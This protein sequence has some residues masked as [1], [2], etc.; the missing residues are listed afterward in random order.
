MSTGEVTPLAG[1]V[2]QIAFLIGGAVAGSLAQSTSLARRQFDRLGES[3]KELRARLAEHAKLSAL[4]ARIQRLSTAYRDARARTEG[5]SAAFEASAVAAGKPTAETRRLAREWDKARLKEE[6]LLVGLREHSA[7]AVELRGRIMGVSGAVRDQRQEERRLVASLERVNAVMARNAKLQERR[8]GILRARS[9][10]RMGMVDAYL[11]GRVALGPL[12]AATEAESAR[13]RLSTV[14][15]GPEKYR[16]EAVRKAWEVGKAMAKS[17]LTGL[18]EG[19]DIQYALESAGLEA[20]LSRAAAPVVA[21]VAKLTRGAPEEVGE[22]LATVYNNLSKNFAGSAEQRFARVGDLLT[23]VQFKYQIRDFG[24]L[25]ESMKY[26][27]AGINQYKVDAEQSFGVIGALNTYGLQGSMAGTAFSAMVRGLVKGTKD[28]RPQIVRAKDG[29]MD[30]VRTLELLKQDMRFMTQDQKARFLTDLEGDEGTRGIVP[31]LENLD[32]LKKDLADVREGSKG[33]VSKEMERWS[34]TAE[35]RFA[36][37]RGAVSVGAEA[38]GVALLPFAETG[39][40]A[41]TVLADKIVA[42]SE[43]YPLATK[44][45]ADFAVG[46]IGAKAAWSVGKY[47]FSFPADFIV[48]IMKGKKALDAF[49]LTASG[50]K[51][52]GGLKLLGSTIWTRVIP[53]VWGFTVALLTNPLTW[54][55]AGIVATGVA[56]ALLAVYWD[57]VKAAFK[58]GIDWVAK[59]WDRLA[60]WFEEKIGRMVAAWR[61]FK[62]ALVGGEG[63]ARIPAVGRGGGVPG[64][65]S[66]ALHVAASAHAEGG[67]FSRPHLGLVAEAG[68]EALVPLSDRGKGLRVLRA[69]GERLGAGPGL[70]TPGGVSAAARV[71]ERVAGSVLVPPRPAPHATR[72]PDGGAFPSGGRGSGALQAAG[73]DLAFRGGRGGIDIRFAPVI[74]IAGNA[75]RDVLDEALARAKTELRRML[76]DLGH[77]QRRLS[78]A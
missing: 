27:A 28:Y 54:V 40:S 61:S 47:A 35:A 56:L 65:V 16:D 33:L 12:Q 38:L 2:M 52:L 39:A 49:A 18:T 46:M 19:M 7:R 53:A 11:M 78:L 55:V 48:G 21:G 6:A 37:M 71:A 1:K 20:A 57:D 24:Q 77:D 22:V 23:K 31:L 3:A 13:F 76:L 63:A 14:T 10:A 73:E 43:K 8:E 69:A 44:V 9:D 51:L 68:P 42:L 45:I 64:P 72:G 74:R 66:T 30:L 62:A 32:T 29:T 41:L 15:V 4:Q 17:G 34:K 5:L 70:G 60:A 58:A 25:G 59:A 36:R 50:Q 67:I 26:A 75:D